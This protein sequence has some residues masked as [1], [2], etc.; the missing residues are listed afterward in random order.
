MSLYVLVRL[1]SNLKN[2]TLKTRYYLINA[3]GLQGVVYLISTIYQI[4]NVFIIETKYY[5]IK[6]RSDELVIFGVN[7]TIY[8]FMSYVW[9]K[10][11][12]RFYLVALCA[13]KR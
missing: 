3:V 13:K 11:M 7:A 5:D 10:D 6:D 12:K 8:L 2:D 9:R 1:F 4:T